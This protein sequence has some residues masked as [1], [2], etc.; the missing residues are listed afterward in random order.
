MAEPAVAHDLP[1]P[2]PERFE[3][4][5]PISQRLVLV[6]VSGAVGQAKPS[7]RHF[8]GVCASTSIE[9]FGKRTADMTPVETYDPTVLA[10]TSRPKAASALALER[11][12]AASECCRWASQSRADA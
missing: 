3:R 6:R 4:D 10:W 2:H 11:L 5:H 7:G 8:F 9:G 1:Q 12:Y